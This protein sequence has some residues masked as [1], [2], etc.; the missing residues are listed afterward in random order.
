MPH[1]TC[2]IARMRPH[3]AQVVPSFKVGVAKVPPSLASLLGKGR[4]TIEDALDGKGRPGNSTTIDEIE[5]FMRKHFDT[6]FS[7]FGVA[8]A[9]AQLKGKGKAKA[10]HS[11][12][13]GGA[14][15][16]SPLTG[17]DCGAADRTSLT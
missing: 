2:H 8:L 12:L 17:G 4:G 15:H 3:R 6:N 9:V 7:E 5:A 13:A 14:P 10:A 16:D 11:P 1:A